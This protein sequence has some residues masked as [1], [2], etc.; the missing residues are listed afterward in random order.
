MSFDRSILSALVAELQEKHGQE[1]ERGD[2][3]IANSDSNRSSR[4]KKPSLGGDVVSGHRT[5][6]K[7]SGGRRTRGIDAAF[8][9]CDKTQSRRNPTFANRIPHPD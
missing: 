7:V 2:G 8:T 1:E 3:G 4:G 5:A 6:T 9:A